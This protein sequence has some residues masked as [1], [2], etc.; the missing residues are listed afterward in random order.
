MWKETHKN[1]YPDIILS[2]CSVVKIRVESQKI[3]LTFSQYGFFK[4]ANPDSRYYRTDGGE[5]IITGCAIDNLSIKE[6]RTQQLS[7]DLYFETMYD[8]ELRNFMERINKGIWRFEIVEEFYA[9]GKGFYTGQIHTD[10]GSFWCHIIV[11]FRDLTYC[12]NN[13]IPDCPF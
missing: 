3:V 7:D 12:W 4:K 8:I 6:V 11:P 5:I 1:Q 10:G 2:D 9:V 13:T